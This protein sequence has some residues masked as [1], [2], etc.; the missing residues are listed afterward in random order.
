[1]SKSDVSS[2]SEVDE[3]LPAPAKPTLWHRSKEHMKRFCWAY[4]VAF[5]ISVLVI[6]LPLSYVGIPNFA[7]DYIDKYEYDYDGLEITNPRPTAFHIKQTQSLRMGGGFSGSGHMT[8][9]NAT[10]RLKDTDEVLT[11]FPVPNIAFGNGATLEIDQ[12]LDLSCVDCLSQLA[13][14]A[15]SNKSS[16]ILV[17]GSPDLKFGALPTARLNIHKIMNV[18]NFINAEGAFN[19]TS[20]ELLDPPI[21]GYN[22][23]AT[24]SVRNP[25]P[26][27]VELG[28][29]T[30]NLT[31]GDSDL[32]WVDLPY[33]F[34]EKEISSTVVRGS[35]DKQ[36]LIHEAISGDDEIGIVTIG[37]HGRSCSFKGVDI[38]YFTAAVKAMSASA[39]IDLLEYASSLFS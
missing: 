31:L 9:F 13:S 14:A 10:C 33:F 38:P 5:C 34:L 1:M 26:F 7:N 36:M 16:S 25:S 6:I 19:V 35:V 22:F 15:A 30:F 23:N 29:V 8:A 4:L 17:E 18:A 3:A 24:I 2:K 20:I 39:R 27:I 11:V 32:G 12:D 28:H 37:V 21:D